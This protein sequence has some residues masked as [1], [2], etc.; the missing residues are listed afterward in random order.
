MVDAR[1][2]P[3][4]RSSGV[5]FLAA[6]VA[7]VATGANEEDAVVSV[8][9]SFDY[10]TDRDLY[11]NLVEQVRRGDPS[12][13]IADQS[14]RSAVHDDTWKR[15]ARRRIRRVDAVIFI[16]GVNTHSAKGVE[17]EMSITQDERKPY[18]LLKGRRDGS[19]KPRNARSTDILQPWHWR[20]IESFLRR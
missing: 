12:I 14:L 11:G 13:A 6:R 17:A 2:N 1:P 7:F 3:G 19:S 9:V 18:L 5:Q 10:D 16:C 8:F 4:N 20:K 15:E